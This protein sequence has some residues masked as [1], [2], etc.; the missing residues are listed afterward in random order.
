[1]GIPALDVRFPQQE[2]KSTDAEEHNDYLKK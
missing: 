2:G 1:M